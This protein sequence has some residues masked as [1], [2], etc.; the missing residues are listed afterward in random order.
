MLKHACFEK[1]L[2]L[3]GWSTAR[4]TKKRNLP[5]L[6]DIVQDF[7]RQNGFRHLTDVDSAGWSPMCYA[8]LSGSAS[9]VAALLAQGANPNDATRNPTCREE[10]GC[11]NNIQSWGK[12]REKQSW[13]LRE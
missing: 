7:L 1:E 4:A 12:R 9:V 6:G 2:M 11:G 3:L 13:M 8:A 5:E 10:F